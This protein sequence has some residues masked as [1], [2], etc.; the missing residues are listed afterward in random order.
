MR[1]GSQRLRADLGVGTARWALSSFLKYFFL[2]GSKYFCFCLN[3]YNFF[4]E[5]DYDMAECY[6]CAGTRV[7]RT[8]K[9]D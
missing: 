4:F 9:D 3:Y 6:L 5:V 8:T 1:P 7:L 2:C